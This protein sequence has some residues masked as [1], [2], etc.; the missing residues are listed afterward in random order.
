MSPIRK[1]LAKLWTCEFCN[2]KFE[3]TVKLGLHLKKFKN[4]RC[5][6]GTAAA[7]APR[8]VAAA[9]PTNPVP[10][11]PPRSTD[12][13][14]ELREKMSKFSQCGLQ[15]MSMVAHL[16][17]GK[18]LSES[19]VDKVLSFATKYKDSTDSLPFKNCSQYK[20]FVDSVLMSVDDGWVPCYLN[21]CTTRVL[22]TLVTNCEWSAAM[23][24]QV[25]M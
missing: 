10:D 11:V 22:R 23:L 17:N 5:K 18:G 13:H 7:P 12:I 9:P 4:G 2:S 8:P 6:Q 16:N 21:Q 15:F 25:G 14:E 24:W 19:D 20:V 3:Q 1:P